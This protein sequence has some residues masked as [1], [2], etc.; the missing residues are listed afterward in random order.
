MDSKQHRLL[1]VGCGALAQGVAARLG[2]QNWQHLG[3]RRR[4]ELLPP[5]ITPLAVDLLADTCPEHWPQ[6]A[7]DYVLVTLSP[8][9]RSEAS[10]RRSYLDAQRNLYGWL[11]QHG[12]VPKQ[13]VFV[14]STGVYAQDG[15][16][17]VDEY[18]LTQPLR[19]SGRVMLEAEQLAQASGIPCTLVRLAGIYGGQRQQFLRRVQAGYHAQGS[20]N[21]YTNRIHE[22]DAISLLAHL[23]RQLTDGVQLEAVY[24][25]VD[26][27]PVEQQE[28]VVWLQQQLGV[29]GNEDLRLGKPGSSKRCSNA[30]A[31]SSGWQPLYKDFRQGYLELLNRPDA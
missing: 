17:W 12:Q 21:R 31:K 16:Q 14:S 23:L 9:E 10:Y 5:E 15:G 8:D 24:I 1:L 30:L 26:D 4:A 11:A 22:Q 13:V 29:S 7:I 25:G 6:G 27:C 18:S 19:W 28:V 20:V 3:L 2:Q